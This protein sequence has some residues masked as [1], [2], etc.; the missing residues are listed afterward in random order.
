NLQSKIG[1]V[2]AR[3]RAKK[4][5]VYFGQDLVLR[6]LEVVDTRQ[7]RI[8]WYGYELWRANEELWWYDSWPHPD[9]PKL[10]ITHPHHQH[11][12]PDIKHHR[13]PAPSLSFDTPNLPFLILK[14]EREY[15]GDQNIET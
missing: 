2:A 10:A 4:G 8:E 6:V 7:R 11:I 3:G 5:E 12:P 1:L 13:I 9:T 14:I 15:L